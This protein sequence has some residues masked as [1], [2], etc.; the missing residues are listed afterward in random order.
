MRFAVAFFGMLTLAA[1]SAE[2]QE[3]S[4]RAMAHEAQLE[5][6]DEAVEAILSRDSEAIRS[7][8]P[9]DARSYYSDEN[10]SQL[11]EIM[12]T[13]GPSKVT[14]A[15]FNSGTMTNN[16]QTVS[17]GEYTYI[18]YFG[19]NEAGIERATVR[20]QLQA[21]GASPHYLVHL[22]FRDRTPIDN[23]PSTVM[24]PIVQGLAI[25]VA[26]FSIITLLV[27]IFT[28]RLKRRILWSAFIILV[29]TPVFQFVTPGESW[30]YLGPGPTWDGE[31]FRLS[32]FMVRVFSASYTTDFLSGLTA[33]DIAVPVGALAF[34]FQRLTGRLAR[35]PKPIPP[36]ASPRPESAS[37]EATGKA[38]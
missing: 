28:P 9:P 32:I 22:N 34:W 23:M 36:S 1:C 7:L 2:Q 25:G 24:T 8:A 5:R 30:Q 13:V 38:S 29:G 20:I 19:S 11:Y 18:A 14:L 35:K 6:S 21:V 10:L 12:P 4:I 33:Y 27:A 3:S 16:G 31:T 26:A 15:Q 17:N 37:A